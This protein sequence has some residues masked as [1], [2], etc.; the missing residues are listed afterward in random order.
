MIHDQAHVKNLIRKELTGGLGNEDAARLKAAWMLHSEEEMAELEWEVLRELAAT[1]PPVSRPTAHAVIR[2]ARTVARAEAWTVMR[3]KIAA[4]A[5]VMVFVSLLYVTNTLME[6]T[7]P[8]IGQKWR[9]RV[10]VIPPTAFACDLQWGD[11]ER[12]HV[13]G[14]HEGYVG[15]IG[16]LEVRRHLDGE[17]ELLPGSLQYSGGGRQPTEIRITTGARQQAIVRLPGGYRFRLDANS[18]LHYPLAN[19][20]QKHPRVTLTGQ[21]LVEAQPSPANAPADFRLETP[22][23]NVVTRAGIFSVLANETSTRI[24]LLEG[25]AQ[26]DFPANSGRRILSSQGDMVQ[27]D[28]CCVGPGGDYQPKL[29]D[30]LK[31]DL[32]KVLLWTGHTREYNDVPLREFVNAELRRWH[33]MSARSLTCIP[34]DARITATISYEDPVE[35]IFAHLHRLGVPFHEHKG[36]ISFCGPAVDPLRQDMPLAPDTLHRPREL[37]ERLY[38]PFGLLAHHESGRPAGIPPRQGL[39]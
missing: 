18:S 2:N 32:R 21:A 5:A 35:T 25:S 12:L 22:Q 23:G 1:R 10:D 9:K 29:T 24:V 37:L 14:E 20:W 28:L 16:P 7:P 34:D 31:A 26:G 6:R 19:L 15:H 36:M 8:E 17:L 39:Y 11:G 3:P 38:D 30:I 4:V 13:S 33:G 27:Y